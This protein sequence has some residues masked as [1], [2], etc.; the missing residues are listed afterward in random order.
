MSALA[1]VAL[2]GALGAVARYQ[3]SLWVHA[4][5]PSAFPTG[6]LVVNL[7]GC[8]LLGVLAGLVE[9]RMVVSPTTRLFLGV[10][11][12]GAFTT[13]STF[14]LETLLAFERGHAGVALSYVAVSVVIGLLAVWVGL[15]GITS[16]LR[17]FS[18]M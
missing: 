6:T 2:G 7:I 3:L 12:L 4:R 1:A 16:L 11:L 17:R 14:E 8:L 15:E 18:E 13:F 10:G 9:A 5:W